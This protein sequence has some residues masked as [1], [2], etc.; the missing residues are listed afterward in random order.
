MLPKRFC[1]ANNP[2]LKLSRGS[3]VH[4]E[5]LKDVCILRT[6]VGAELFTLEERVCRKAEMR[7]QDEAFSVVALL[8]MIQRLQLLR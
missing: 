1:Y 4:K 2:N 8:S 5:L 7:R 6:S 3:S